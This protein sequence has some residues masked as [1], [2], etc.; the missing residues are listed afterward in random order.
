M[1]SE[2]NGSCFQICLCVLASNIGPITLSYVS[3]AYLFKTT[4]CFLYSKHLPNPT[5]ADNLTKQTRDFLRIRHTC[6]VHHF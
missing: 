2:S 6:R 3:L 1:P 4:D 5:K